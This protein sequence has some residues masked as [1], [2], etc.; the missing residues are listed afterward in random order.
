MP[1]IHRNQQDIPLVHEQLRPEVR[2]RPHVEPAPVDVDHDRLQGTADPVAGGG[3]VDIQGEAVLVAENLAIKNEMR[4]QTG[5][6]W[7]EAFRLS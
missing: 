4:E 3:R 6:I 1:V 5:D 7:L 2:P